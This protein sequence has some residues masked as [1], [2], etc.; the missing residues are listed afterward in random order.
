MQRPTAAPWRRANRTA[1]PHGSVIS[2][3]LG[4]VAG[5]WATPSSAHGEIQRR[6]DAGVHF[7]GN[8]IAAPR[9]ALSLSTNPAGLAELRDFEA[10][11]QLS[12]GGGWVAGTRGAGW[13][14]FLAAPLGGL[15]L[16][17]GVER[18]ADL[19]D[20][21][22]GEP[23]GPLSLT[24]LSLA[25]A[26]SFGD[27]LFVGFA[28]R[29][30]TGVSG[31]P[32][33]W[34][35]GLLYRPWS[36]I[37]LAWR[38][39][40]MTSA[41]N[42]VAGSGLPTFTTRWSWG[43]ALRPFKGSD[44]FMFAWDVTW[45][46]GDHRGSIT[47]QIR[48]RVIDGLAVVGEFQHYRH[49]ATT[50]QT[51]GEDTRASLLLDFGFGKWGV[52]LGARTGKNAESGERGGLQ[53]GVRLSG[54]APASLLDVGDS[55]VVVPLRGKMSEEPGADNH[56]GL[57][58][59]RLDRMADDPQLRL[60]VFRSD[61]VTLTWSQVEELR[62]AIAR[63]RARGKRT[64]WYGAG[65]GTRGYMVASAC[66]R[67]GLSET[68][69]LGARGFGADFVGLS[70]ALT[71]VG[72]T[73]QALR[74]GEYKSGPEMFTR[75]H[76]SKQLAATYG[77]IIRR[78]WRD[79]VTAVATGRS[80]S[81]TQVEAALARGVAFPQD[82]QRA[83]LIDIVAEPKAFERQLRTWGL[84]DADAPLRKFH[85]VPRRRVRWG[86]RDKIAVLA[87]RGNIVDGKNGSGL[88]GNQVGGAEMARTIGGL[89][90]DDSVRALVARID[91]GG[92]AVWGS[93]AMYHA[94]VRFS[95]KKPSVASMAATAASG[96]YWTALGADH[97][98]ANRATIT[99][100]IGIWV[101]KP[102]ISGLLGRLGI[103]V[104]HV[105]AGPHEGVTSLQRPWTT[106]EQALLRRV[107]GRYYDVFL[108]RVSLRRKIARPK[109]LTLAEGR[110]WM[111]DEAAANGL[112]DATG[113]LL[114]SIAEARGRADIADD[115][116]V[117]VVFLPKPTFASR[118]RARL[119]VSVG[120]V[121]GAETGAADA[122]QAAVMRALQSAA[123]PWLGRAM[124]LAN[125]PR[126]TPLV[127]A[128]IL[129]DA[130]GR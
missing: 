90:R 28:A 65:L 115:D 40:G 78:R 129:P 98:I 113:G 62:A 16:G 41:P 74:Y 87:I 46:A 36:W 101:I 96:G 1:L 84:L 44:R 10:R 58:L 86:R 71:R 97:I 103:G 60:V 99:G 82:A 5:L 110:L 47:G 22:T 48:A 119:G 29:A 31:S 128:P 13:G 61:G 125:L 130:G 64:A 51:L 17:F 37:S 38:V 100:S 80:L 81:P 20:G 116:D 45:P 89:R 88:M 91:S 52:D 120:A 56:F 117:A 21:E 8:A 72:V 109:L 2:L 19:P 50:D 114:A 25:A 70:Q 94:L 77:R 123:G 93:D 75:K 15:Q 111:G 127:L 32:T 39:T 55:A 27:R 73:V 57:L 53:L 126:G 12:G 105:G 42:P 43:F 76:I 33:S 54:D 104:S 24:R 68:G 108:Q 121:L 102:D 83:L 9:G 66:E 3:M 18:V 106:A 118:L 6:A 67:I 11:L 49:N 85:E 59:L 14:G 7:A 107:L 112:I 35:A 30:H 124:L 63:L 26:T 23:R 4:L 95:K 122:G 34:D 79:F 69:T 92:G